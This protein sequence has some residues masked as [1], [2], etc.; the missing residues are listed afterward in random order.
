M[1]KFKTKEEV[2][3]YIW[4]LLREKEVGLFPLF[5]RIPNFLGVEK[6]I[7]KI[8]ELEEFKEA[9]KI[10]IS[11]DTPQRKILELIDLKEKE[12]YMATPRLIDGFVKLETFKKNLKDLLEFSKKIAKLP[13]ID[14]ALIGSVAVDIKG[15]RI[16]K[17]GG[18]GDR[19]I[20]M[21]REINEKVVVASNVHD[22]QVLED[23][24]YLA[25]P[26]DEKIDLIITPTRI[27]KCLR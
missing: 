18:Y 8:L 22:L 23:L 27:V 20:R 15:N 26:H 7:E 11:P 17:G 25:Q 2:R 13:K 4:N 16:G 1:N 5:G 14:F 10:F 3:V 6:S 19:E 21:L 24:S 12:V 9:K